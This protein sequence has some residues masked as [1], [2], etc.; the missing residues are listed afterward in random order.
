MVAWDKAGDGL[1]V[2]LHVGNGAVLL[3]EYVNVDLPLPNVFLTKERPDLVEQFLTDESDYYGRH[4]AKN[5]ATW[6][7]GP[8][9]QETVC[10]VYGSFAFLPARSGTVSEVLSRQSFEHL[11]RTQARAALDECYRVLKSGG[12]LRIDIPDPDETMRLYR[13]TGDE[14]YFRHLFGPRRDS[15]GGH[16]HYNRG[17][18]R[19]LVEEL[20]FSFTEEERN[21]HENYPAFCLRWTKN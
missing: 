18:L 15:F 11:D 19:S 10:D 4:K 20:R 21:I 1:A 2:R 3:R 7:K 9:Q 8:I 6:R 14:F 16:T 13:E 17:M 12:I 5:T